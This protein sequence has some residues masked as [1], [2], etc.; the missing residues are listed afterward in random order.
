[1]MNRPAG[2]QQLDVGDLALV[3]AFGTEEGARSGQGQVVTR[4]RDVR[5]GLGMASDQTVHQEETGPATALGSRHRA[6]PSTFPA[7]KSG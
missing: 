5:A 1:M 6:S 3:P 4:G 2:H 7:D